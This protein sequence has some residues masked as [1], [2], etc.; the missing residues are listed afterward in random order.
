MKSRHLLAAI[1]IFF[2]SLN[3]LSGTAY[4]IAATKIRDIL[5]HPRDFENKE[6]TVHGTVTNAVSLVVIKYFEIR[7]N[8]GSIKI[9]TDKLLPSRDEK[10]TVIGRMAVV[11]VGPER[12]VVLREDNDSSR[13]EVKSNPSA[14]A[15]YFKE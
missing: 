5:D 15:E 4:S 6:I 10:L 12:W 8:T 2:A 11:E 3:I 7:D 14:A 9:L 13:R 1:V